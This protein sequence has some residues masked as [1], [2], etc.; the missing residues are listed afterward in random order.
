MKMNKYLLQVLFSL[1]FLFQFNN[2]HT[3]TPGCTDPNAGNYDPA[4]TENDGSC[5]Y[6]Q[7]NYQPVFLSDLAT[8]V[9]ETSGLIAWNGSLWTINDSGNSPTL[10]ELDSSSGNIVNHYHLKQITNI[11][12]EAITQ[13]DSFIFIGDFGNNLGNRQDLRI[14]KIAKSAI[15]NAGQDSVANELIHFHYPEQQSFIPSNRNT[16]WDAEAF[17][18][19]DHALH[20]FTKDWTNEHTTHY[21]L[22]DTAGS[23]AAQRMETF[24]SQGLITDVS[25][26]PANGH[27]VLLGYTKTYQAFAW[28]LFDYQEG[29]L[30]S[31]NKRR[32]ELPPTITL[33]QVE[34]ICFT[35]PYHGRISGEAIVSNTLGINVPPKLYTFDFTP[36]F[37]PGN[38]T[39]IADRQ[40]TNYLHAYPNPAKEAITITVPRDLELHIR[41]SAGTLTWTKSLKKGTHTISCA[42]WAKGIYTISS[43]GYTAVKISI[44]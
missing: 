2:S 13:N 40:G 19:Q 8:P 31:G 7:S 12:W 34:G 24:Q 35:G 6:P 30:F 32:L 43:K 29:L 22:P 25:R 28:L 36:Y 10:F 37:T 42:G 18:W 3:Q 21:R 38:P 1:C 4:A 17:F 44:N 5:L 16:P 15:L 26:N 23:Y 9:R 14:I 39:L 27:I 20:I 33:G 11:D 41:N